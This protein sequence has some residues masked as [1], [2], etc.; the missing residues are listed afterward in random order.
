MSSH[1]KGI[2]SDIIDLIVS[3]RLPRGTFNLVDIISKEIYAERFHAFQDEITLQD[4]SVIGEMGSWLSPEQV[5]T[6]DWYVENVVGKLPQLEN[7]TEEAK[8]LIALQNGLLPAT[9]EN[10]TE[11]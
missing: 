7:L 11:D 8:E 2:S 9:A 1:E 10:V 5:I 6:M 3:K 4:G